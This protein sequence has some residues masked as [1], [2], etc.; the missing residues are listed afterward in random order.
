MTGVPGAGRSPTSSEDAPFSPHHHCVV[1]GQGISVLTEVLLH[2]NT[3]LPGNYMVNF[4]SVQFDK[5]KENISWWLA[6]GKR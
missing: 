2:C 5:R 3:I 1:R 6:T 4:S